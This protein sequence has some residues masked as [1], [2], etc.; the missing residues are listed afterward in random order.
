MFGLKC[1]CCTRP[2]TFPFT[3]TVFLDNGD[4]YDVHN[5]VP[6]GVEDGVRAVILYKHKDCG[7]QGRYSAKMLRRKAKAEARAKEE[8]RRAS[9]PVGPQGRVRLGPRVAPWV[10][11]E[12]MA[13]ELVKMGYTVLMR[14]NRIAVVLPLKK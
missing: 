3:C 14:R 10:R 7:K 4:Q 11:H 8:Q 9:R 5:K 6:E 2:L 12:L 1:T 13:E